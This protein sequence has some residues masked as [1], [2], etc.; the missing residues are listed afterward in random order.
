MVDHALYMD[1]GRSNTLA[2][3]GYIYKE[4]FRQEDARQE[5]LAH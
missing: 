1:N 5:R 3:I 2:E 4:A